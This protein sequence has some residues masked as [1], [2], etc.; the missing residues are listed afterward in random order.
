VLSQCFATNI[1]CDLR[2]EEGLACA[3]SDKCCTVKRSKITSTSYWTSGFYSLLHP[4]IL[5]FFSLVNCAL[6][7]LQRQAAL[8]FFI[9]KRKLK[10]N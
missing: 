8:C 10:W 5:I 3:V 2:H 9:N 7:T 4:A 6:I 1:L